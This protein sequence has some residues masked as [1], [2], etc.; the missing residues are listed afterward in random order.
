MRVNARPRRSWGKRCHAQKNF[1]NAVS[2]VAGEERQYEV[3]IQA[4]AEEGIRRDRADVDDAAGSDMARDRHGGGHVLWF[5]ADVK[6]ELP[7]A[8]AKVKVEQ[9]GVDSDTN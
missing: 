1:P 6:H 9:Q 8:L 7:D 2:A 4:R 5:L 3:P